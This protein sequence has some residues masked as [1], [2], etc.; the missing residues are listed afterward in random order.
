MNYNSNQF[1]FSAT[2]YGRVLKFALSAIMAEIEV[3]NR[4]EEGEL[5]LSDV[6][7]HSS[8][9]STAKS[10]NKRRSRYD[11]LEEQWNT[12]FNLLLAKIDSIS[13]QSRTTEHAETSSKNS[14]RRKHGKP[15]ST[16]VAESSDS[17]SS[18][19]DDAISLLACGQLSDSSSDDENSSKHN[20]QKM[21][22]PISAKK[23]LFDIFGED[24]TIKKQSRKVGIVLDESQKQVIDSGYRCQTPNDLTA[25]SE[26][27]IDLF[28][29]DEDTDK[30]LQVPTLDDLVETC[31]VNR[32]GSKASFR[33]NKARAL[34]SQPCKMVEKIAYRGQQAA[35]LGMIIQ[36]YMQQGLASLVENISSQEFD[37]DICVNKIKDIFS[38][39][40]KCL[41]QISR[42]G[43]FHHITRRTVA[44]SDTSLY[45]LQDSNDFANLP[46]SGEGVFGAGLESI[47]KGRKE[48]KKQFDEMLPELKKK[49]R[50]RKASPERSALAD[51]SKRARPDAQLSATHSGTW[52]NFRIPKVPRTTERYGARS[53]NS[54]AYNYKP[55]AEQS[56]KIVS[57]GGRQGV[58]K[59][60]D[61]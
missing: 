20:G 12:K 2:E 25:F 23:C 44:M 11:I 27:N 37:S 21:D 28:P 17:E 57:P 4:R 49:D 5:P 36:L 26:E 9:P 34:F 33:K 61:K 43:A 13:T 60:A 45:G 42:A 59:P 38:M 54:R 18:D 53:G 55:R 31:L 1:L 41:D 30:Y 51:V 46:L 14:R 32:Y 29:I 22:K 6:E 19:N 3:Q 52:N 56:R 58:G 16:H 47:L 8:T 39:S 10:A 15:V 50:K 24:A 35:K 48:K 40:T 7:S